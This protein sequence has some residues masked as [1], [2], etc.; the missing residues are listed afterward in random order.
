MSSVAERN[1][2]SPQHRKPP[3]GAGPG[4]CASG[5]DGGI[6]VRLPGTGWY[7]ACKTAADVAAAA[8]L[9]VATAPLILLAVVL[10]KLT[11]KGPAFYS[12]TRLGRFG[13]PYLICKI[14][15]MWHDAERLS[16]PQWCKKGDPRITPVGRI[17]RLTHI[18]ELPQLWNVLRGE[19][20]LLGPRPERPEIARELN[21]VIPHY[22]GRLLL[23]PGLSGLAQ[24]QL[25]PDTDLA[26]VR[27]K[28]AYDLYYVQHVGPWL[29]L[30]LVLATGCYLL[31]VPF[32]VTRKLLAVPSGAAV[33]GPYEK[34]LGLPAKAAPRAR[35]EAVGAPDVD[36][37]TM[38]DGE[39]AV[40]AVRWGYYPAATE[41]LL[42]NNPVPL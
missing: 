22:S 15:T 41:L 28:L 25:P 4:P 33:E 29:D 24:V 30:R 40:L 31:K 20:S 6:E 13:R 3:A 27:L 18:D 10:V 8:L 23:R 1:V 39:L 35:A 12:Q 38:A 42:R 7:A 16:G 34:L 26:S 14:R 11:S 5:K 17:L 32:A 37:G 2:G 19:M 36:L 21:R 9:L